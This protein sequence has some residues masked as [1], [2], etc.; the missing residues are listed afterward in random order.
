MIFANNTPENVQVELDVC[1]SDY[2]GFKADD[3]IRKYAGRIPVL[4]MKD[5]YQE[6]KLES[7]PYALIGN[8]DQGGGNRSGGRGRFEFRPLG[9][10]VMDL[11]AVIE[12]ACTSGVKWLCVEQDEPSA[13]AQDRFEGPAISIQYLRDNL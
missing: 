1:W 2:A 4:H 6:G 12:A 13:G 8:A 3:L 7:D 10:G 5:Y 9:K 11:A